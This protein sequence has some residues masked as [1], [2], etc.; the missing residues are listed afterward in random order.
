MTED[1]RAAIAGVFDR[2]APTYDAVGVDFFSV[3]G[4]RL[5]ADV[6][7]SAG[8]RVLDVGCGRG[9][10][11][12]PAAQAVGPGGEVVGIDLAPAMVAATAA[13]AR[14]L[15]L[16][17]VEVVVGDAQEP[18]V[19]GPFDVVLAGLVLFFLP[20]PLAA[21]RSYAGLLRPAGRLAFTWFGPDDPRWGWLGP[22]M[23]ELGAPQS[24]S[25]TGH[26]A[27]VDSVH[28]FVAQGGFADVATRERTHETVFT[29]PQQWLTWV[30]S[31]G[32]RFALER[33]SAEQLADFQSAAYTEL[34]R[35]SEADGSITLRSVVRYTVARRS[36]RQGS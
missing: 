32:M 8:D 17:H 22:L 9:A 4:A 6:G 14:R 33:A 36:G 1:R 28:A 2:A 35:M 26:F 16:D 18:P 19:T 10:S 31:Q 23:R 13:D 34:T 12:L 29:D 25:R 11:L 5:V 7:V 3:F 15:H 20:D 27:D 21:V 24:P 30:W